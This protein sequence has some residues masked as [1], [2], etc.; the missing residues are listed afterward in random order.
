MFISVYYQV[1]GIY[2]EATPL[3]LIRFLGTSPDSSTIQP[4]L[5]SLCVQISFL[6][7]QPIDDIPSDLV[8]LQVTSAVF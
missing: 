4:L 7:D 6:Y 5:H 3:L 1:R 2:S 8:L